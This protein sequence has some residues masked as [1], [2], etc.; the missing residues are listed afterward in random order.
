M[1]A[2]VKVNANTS[3]V[4]LNTKP[5]RMRTRTRNLPL[6][7]NCKH[8]YRSNKRVPTQTHAKRDVEALT[9][10]DADP[11]CTGHKSWTDNRRSFL[12]GAVLAGVASDIFNGKRETRVEGDDFI[13]QTQHITYTPLMH[14]CDT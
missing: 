4:C 8:P 14:K 11:T 5:T 6:Q 13:C 10:F 9:A 2:Q 3:S 12:K 1:P 7:L